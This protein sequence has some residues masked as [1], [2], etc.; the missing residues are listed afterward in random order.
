MICCSF[1]GMSCHMQNVPSE[2]TIR[3][4]LIDLEECSRYQVAN[5]LWSMMD[6]L[7]NGGDEGIC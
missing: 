2:N 4:F 5:Q 3:R 7:G 1:S 6:G